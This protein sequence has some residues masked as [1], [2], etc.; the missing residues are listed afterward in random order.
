MQTLVMIGVFWR[1]DR[2][3]TLRLPYLGKLGPKSDLYKSHNLI[4]ILKKLNRYFKSEIPR[5]HN[6]V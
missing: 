5:A 4:K 2:E 3:G 1:D 6:P